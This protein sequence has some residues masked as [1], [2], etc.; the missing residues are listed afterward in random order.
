MSQQINLFNPIFLK[1]KKYFSV[2]AMLQAL[3]LVAAGCVLFY[4]YASSQVRQLA[5]QSEEVGKRYAAEQTRLDNFR[6]QYSPQQA[7]QKLEKEVKVAEAKLLAQ[8]DIIDTL[9]SGALGNTDGYSPYMLA[10]AR[11]I[12]TGLWLTGFSISGDA[13][14]L[15]LNGA[16]LSDSPELIPTY[17][18]KLGREDVMRGKSF[19]ALQI[20]Q[21]HVKHDKPAGYVEF[22]LQSQDKADEIK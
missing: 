1:Q 3:L 10:F 14:Q 9:K 15:N 6:L 13:A 20:R 4:V 16:V 21:P 8:R 19:A 7:R 2:V 11:Q 18:S 12:V 17:V 5:A 22:S